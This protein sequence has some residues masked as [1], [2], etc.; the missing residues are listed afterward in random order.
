MSVSKL[1]RLITSRTASVKAFSINLVLVTSFQNLK[2][3]DF[4]IYLSVMYIVRVRPEEW[5]TTKCSICFLCM[6]FDW[7]TFGSV[8]NFVQL[9]IVSFL[10]F[11]QQF[12]SKQSQMRP[13]KAHDLETK[14]FTK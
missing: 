10:N 5:V 2:F 4:I 8:L 6:S 14:C 3:Q 11:T 1:R 7:S 12:N 9:A 13:V